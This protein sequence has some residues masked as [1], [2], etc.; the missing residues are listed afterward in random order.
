MKL[1]VNGNQE[2]AL[3]D[4][5]VDGSTGMCTPEVDAIGYHVEGPATRAVLAKDDET[6]GL[7]LNL[8][9]PGI[10]EMAIVI[11]REDVKKLKALMNKDAIKFMVKALM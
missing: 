6:D 2:L 10:T 1:L 11:G 4:L 5:D 8:E 7:R 3:V 9:L